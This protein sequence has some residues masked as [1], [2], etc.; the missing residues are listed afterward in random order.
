MWRAS[1]TC[2]N[3]VE[4]VVAACIARMDR[5]AF[6]PFPEIDFKGFLFE[7]KELPMY[8]CFSRKL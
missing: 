3:A 7:R 4:H 2:A 8:Q 1:F 5:R 6:L